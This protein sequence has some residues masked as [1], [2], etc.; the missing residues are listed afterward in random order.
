[1][2]NISFNDFKKL[3][4]KVGEIKTVED[5]E[6][7]DKIYQLMVDIGEER[8]L[9]AGIKPWYSKEELVGKKVAVVAN[10][11]PKTIRGVESHGMVLAAS[12][13]DRSALTV[14]TLD[15]DLPNG[16]NIS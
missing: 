7:A 16:S 5:I 8:K 14:L 4:L 3:E 6:G 13:A 9:V 2:E 15:K 11:E 10:L 1:M 12:T